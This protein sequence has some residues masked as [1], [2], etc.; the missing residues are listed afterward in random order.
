MRLR[1]STAPSFF[2]CLVMFL[3]GNAWAAEQ[4]VDIGEIAKQWPDAF[5]LLGT[6]TEPTWIEHVS[7]RRRGDVFL[8]EGGGLGGLEQVVEAVHVTKTGAIQHLACP[9]MRDCSEGEPLSGFLAS[10][11]FLAYH[12][13]SRL[14]GSA[15]VV[16]YGDRHVFCLPAEM[17]G[18][19]DPILDPC[20]D[21]ATGAVLAQRHRNDGSF[22]GPSLDASTIRFLTPG[23]A[24]ARSE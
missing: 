3:A 11:Q 8:L 17:I 5:D 24:D 21:V 22:D 9:P 12:R 7:L 6:K 2:C 10:A 14:H 23:A 4:Q 20:F 13:S 19:Q 16:P 1:S 15:A 18:V